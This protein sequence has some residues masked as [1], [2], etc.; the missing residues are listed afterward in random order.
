LRNAEQQFLK[1]N[2]IVAN[3]KDYIQF[4]GSRGRVS[5]I[6]YLPNGVDIVDRK[7]AQDHFDN[8]YANELAKNKFILCV[9]RITKEKN[10]IT[11]IKA[12]A[13][14]KLH[15][16]NLVIVGNSAHADCYMSDLKKYKKSV[17]IRFMGELSRS[18]LNA[19]YSCCKLFVTPS[20]YEG[21]PNVLLEAMSFNCNILVSRISAHL[22]FELDDSDYFDP[23]D[24][25]DLKSKMLEKLINVSS[26]DY[27]SKLA[28][29]RWD[30]VAK[31]LDGIHKQI[32]T[33][34]SI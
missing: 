33:H 24:T 7:I 6:S 12:F 32:L 26:S 23:L 9:G 4:L 15:E 34:E 16:I 31:K 10:I 30:S 5:G 25:K 29:Y 2:F 17:S 13:E 28:D 14:L 1:A 20:L 8:R 22:Q 3:N 19:L 11:L 21:M 18:D 27:T